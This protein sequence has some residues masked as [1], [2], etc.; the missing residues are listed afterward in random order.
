MTSQ[1]KM[2]EEAEMDMNRYRRGLYGGVPFNITE[3]HE[4]MTIVNTIKNI[5]KD[6]VYWLDK[7]K[8]PVE[9]P[10]AEAL[11]ISAA[12]MKSFG[13]SLAGDHELLKVHLQAYKDAMLPNAPAQNLNSNAIAPATAEQI[14]AAKVAA[15]APVASS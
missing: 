14:A 8:K 15:N 13:R 9:I 2:M 5:G 3:A 10:L 6:K 12:L 4:F 1:E 7:N 11:K